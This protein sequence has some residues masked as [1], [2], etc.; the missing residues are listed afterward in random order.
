MIS[1]KVIFTAALKADTTVSFAQ[2]K[3]FFSGMTSWG[4]P[5]TLFALICT[6]LVPPVM[7]LVKGLILFADLVPQ[8]WIVPISVYL[9][10]AFAILTDGMVIV[11]GRT[12][13]VK[14]VYRQRPMALGT[15]LFRYFYL[16]EILVTSIIIMLAGPAPAKAPIG[17]FRIFSKLINW[18]FNSALGTNFRNHGNK[19]PFGGNPVWCLSKRAAKGP[20]NNYRDFRLLRQVQL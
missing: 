11:P 16:G 7:L 8:L 6:L 1:G 2:V 18:L 15:R 14:S 3:P 17:V 13:A 19:K 9:V 10:L 12:G 20:E 5:Y 4:I